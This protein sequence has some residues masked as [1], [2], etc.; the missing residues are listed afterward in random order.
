MPR[1]NTPPADEPAPR[2]VEEAYQ[3]HLQRRAAIRASRGDILLSAADRALKPYRD[4]ADQILRTHGL[5]MG[6]P[7]P[8]PRVDALANHIDLRHAVDAGDLSEAHARELAATRDRPAFAATMSFLRFDALANHPDLRQAVEAEDLSEAHARDLAGARDQHALAAALRDVLAKAIKRDREIAC[9]AERSPPND[10]TRRLLRQMRDRAKKLRAW[11]DTPPSRVASVERRSN[12][13]LR[14]LR[15]AVVAVTLASAPVRADCNRLR[16]RL[17]TSRLDSR[18]LEELLRSLESELARRGQHSGR[19]Q[20]RHAA[21]ARA[22]CLVWL[23]A[24]QTKTYD[25]DG[26]ILKGAL[27]AFVRDTLGACDLKL[28]DSAL[29]AL[30][31]RQLKYCRDR[32]TR[33]GAPT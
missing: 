6:S 1:R 29:Q 9:H 10:V 24:G 12:E 4:C 26:D 32:V 25:W 13:L 2:V 28:P 5:I 16:E 17:Q 11:A 20:G 19:R 15:S 27:P 7:P 30:L 22:C 33:A 18:A 31:A 23:R 3:R 8:D 21:L 14:L